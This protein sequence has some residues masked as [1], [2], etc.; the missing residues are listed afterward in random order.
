MPLK[1]FHALLIVSGMVLLSCS[2][3]KIN[4]PQKSVSDNGF[5]NQ[6]TENNLSEVLNFVSGTVKKL[7]CIAFYKSYTFPQ[8]NSIMPGNITDSV[9]K[10]ASVGTTVSNQSVTG[11]ATLIYYQDNLAGLLTCAH[12]V[13]FPDT[14]IVR[15]NNG[16]GPIMVISIKV[17]QQNYV[18]DLPL[19]GDVEVVAVD[20]KNDLALLMKKTG[21][22]HE[23]VR[24]LN[25]P[26]G[27]SRELDWGTK[28]Y[29][30]GYPLGKLM[31]TRAMVSK[32]ARN[33]G[34]FLTDA[35][36][37]RGISGSPVLTLH[38]G[39][40]GFEFVGLACSASAR[41]ISYV[42]PGKEHLE[43]INPDEAY[44]GELFATHKKMI[45]YGVTYNITTE[46][47]LDFLSTNR[48]TITEAGL[49]PAM[50]FK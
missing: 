7:D 1:I 23:V 3:Q 20:K 25:C 16:L 42:K 30:M 10:K 35:L 37:N 38:Q 14:I 36:Y 21:E 8:G 11:T 5:N 48:E 17:E 6:T 31:V 12:V 32:P 4:G 29:V 34:R 26:V 18:R 39:V 43:Y 49:N 33:T 47:I 9:L 24:V 46:A 2:A 13:N 19:G 45:N 50:F 28:V 22:H 27:E 44:T 15:Y 41:D 40:P